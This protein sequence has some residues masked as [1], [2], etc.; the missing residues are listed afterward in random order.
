M[1]AILAISGSHMDLL[2]QDPQAIIIALHHRQNAIN[3]LN[4]AFSRWPS[5]PDEAH[6]ML[7]TSYLL[8]FQSGYMADGFIDHILS[9]RG[10]NLLLEAIEKNR[11]EGPFLGSNEV[12]DS[13][14]KPDHPLR[15]P[16]VDQDLLLNGFLSLQA[17]AQ[18]VELPTTKPIEKELYSKLFEAL[19]HLMISPP[20]AAQRLVKDVPTPDPV[21]ATLATAA[22]FFILTTW[23]HNEV[24]YL[25]S[26]TNTL[27]RI[28]LS[29]FAAIR[30]MQN[31]FVPAASE[32]KQL[33]KALIEWCE[34]IVGS[35]Q[36]NE[37][38]EW[39]KYVQW[40]ASIMKGMRWCLNRKRDL[41]VAD[42]NEALLSNPKVFSGMGGKE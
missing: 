7:A 3:G 19:V 2:R 4:N 24:L 10:C 27:G 29:H 25:L 22:C 37:W 31:P 8:A 41:T 20:S 32:T 17:V 33:V 11:L 9:L 13:I 6:A 35:V 34:E 23:P 36:D 16:I 1:Q 12:E 18:L 42:M 21:R 40:P 39:K 5:N 15:L 38:R 30:F 14:L 28:L 26:P